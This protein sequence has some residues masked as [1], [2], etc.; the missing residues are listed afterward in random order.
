[1]NPRWPI[2]VRAAIST[3]VPVVAGWAAGNVGSGLIATIGAFTS[4]FGG[5]RP[6]LNRGVQVQLAVVSVP[7]RLG[8]PVVSAV[9]VAVVRLRNALAVGLPGAYV[10]ALACAARVSAERAAVSAAGATV[11]SYAEAVGSPDELVTEHIAYGT[12]TASG[13]GRSTNRAHW[14]SRRRA[15]LPEAAARACGGAA[16]RGAA[17]GPGRVPRPPRR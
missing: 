5:D 14:G 15:G 4:R 10:F 11:A 3:A 1:M 9:A 17:T 13:S 6:Y 12:I 2:A 7:P 16:H 8:A